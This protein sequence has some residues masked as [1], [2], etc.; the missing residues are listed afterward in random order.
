ML[1]VKD[2]NPLYWENK[3]L[4]TSLSCSRRTWTLSWVMKHLTSKFSWAWAHFSVFLLGP[5]HT[6]R[7]W[8]N[9]IHEGWPNPVYIKLEDWKLLPFWMI[10]W[11]AYPL[12]ITM[13]HLTS[14]FSW[15]WAHFSVFL[16]APHSWTGPHYENLNEFNSRGL[17]VCYLP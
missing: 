14:K 7:I 11:P 9:S 5:V 8:M 6:M 17:F 1:I 13:K 12:Q 15:A 3:W 4:S 10:S 2:F 16:R